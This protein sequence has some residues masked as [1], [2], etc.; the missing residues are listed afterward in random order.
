MLA[1]LSV[2]DSRSKIEGVLKSRGYSIEFDKP[3]RRY[4]SFVPMRSEKLNRHGVEI[5]VYLDGS[6]RLSRIEVQDWYAFF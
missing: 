4:E 6:D 2:G 3:L 1:N 5:D